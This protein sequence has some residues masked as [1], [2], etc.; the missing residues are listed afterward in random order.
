M[1]MK[2]DPSELRLH[3][4]W[5]RQKAAQLLELGRVAATDGALKDAYTALIIEFDNTA[6]QLDLMANRIQDDPAG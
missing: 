1:R 3:A 5:L 4:E 6:A 2:I